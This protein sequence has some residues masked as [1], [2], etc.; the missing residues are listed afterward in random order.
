M[1]REDVKKIMPSITGEQLDEIMK[2]HG[3]SVAALKAGEDSLKKE[4]ENMK[5]RLKEYENTDIEKI[6]AEEFERGRTDAKKQYE[7]ERISEKTDFVISNCG[8][9]N[10]KALK[11]L[12]DFEQITNA[13]DAESVLKS[14]IEQIKAEN[15]FL[16]EDTAPKPRFTDGKAENANI[17]TKDVFMKM[18]YIERAELFD[19][20]P[21][22]Y[23]K[24]ANS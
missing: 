18:G 17:L 24:L 16:F 9:K 7:K 15:G 3:E 21:E 20:N 19:K 13:E 8:A 4:A 12:L 14:Q 1:K 5:L 10:T 23:T 2:M 6:K 11:A 22:I